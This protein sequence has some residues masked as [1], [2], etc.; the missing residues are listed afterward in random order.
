MRKIIIRLNVVMLSFCLLLAGAHVLHAATEMPHFSLSEVESGQM[1]DSDTFAGKAKLVVFF[2]TWCP[3]CM[4]EVPILKQLQEEY[5]NRGL[6]VV[7]L[8]VDRRLRDVQRF[9]QKNDVNYS[10]LMAD[11]TVIQDF[12]GIP[13]VPVTFLVN[14]SGHVLRKYPG[15]V[16]HKLLEREVKKMLS[17]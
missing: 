3:P 9:V 8:S 12:G 4:A 7:A 16:P 13:G 1:V 10:V 14:K 2:A 11:R 15:L 5:G 6:A 17:E